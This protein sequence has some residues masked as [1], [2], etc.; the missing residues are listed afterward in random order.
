MTCDGL[1]GNDLTMCRAMEAAQAAAEAAAEAAAA[2]AK[3]AEG[4]SWVENLV[5]VAGAMGALILPVAAVWLLWRLWPVMIGIFEKRQFT[6]KVGG[7]ELS[8]QDATDQLQKNIGDLQKK[9]AALEGASPKPGEAKPMA[10]SVVT[11]P[12][13]AKFQAKP[14]ERPKNRRVLWVDDRPSNNAAL[15]AAFQADG[16]RV[17]TVPDSATAL[18]MLKRESGRFDAVLTDMGR[19]ERGRYVPDA[20]LQLAADMTARAMK[21]PVALYS[22]ARLAAGVKSAGAPGVDLATSSPTDIRAFVMRH[23]G[24]DG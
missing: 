15:I 19:D 8:A 9:V 18:D 7:F 2:A 21:V 12:P 24:G 11:G 23:T 20:G 5:A 6:V 14:V 1:T 10:K 17:D 13:G 4:K 3:L 22:S 16:I